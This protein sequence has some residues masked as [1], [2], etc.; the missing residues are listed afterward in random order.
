V[1]AYRQFALLLV[2]FVCLSGHAAWAD[3]SGGNDALQEIVVTAEK[4]ESTVQDTPISMTA[5]SGE[6]LQQEGI[7]G[8][9][10]IIE[11]VPGLSMRTAG[12]GQTELEM[13]GLSSSGGSS[14]TVG[15]YLDDYPLTPAAAALNGKVVID[16][17]LFDLNRVEVL[18]G[19]QGTLY[20]SGSM[21]GTVK[22]VTNV[23]KLNEFEGEVEVIGS[24][25]SGGGFNRGGNLMLNVPLINDVLAMRVVVTDKFT[26]GWISRYVESDFPPPTNP[27]PCGPGWT[28]CVR[29]NVAAVPATDIVPR[30][31]WERLQ[32]GRVEALAQ[33]TSELKITT[34]A[35]YQKIT[36][37]D[38]SEYDAPPG[39]PD[40]HYQPFNADEP[41]YDEFKL[42]GLTASYDFPFAQLT[43]ATAYYTREENQTQDTSEALYSVEGLFGGVPTQFYNIPFNETDSTRQFSEEIRLASTGDG[44]LQWIGG[45]FF[46]KFESIFTEYNASV[47]LAYLSVG[48]AAAN[49][50]GIIYQAHNPYH[51]KQYAVFGQGEYSFAD[52]WK[53][54]AGLR[55]YKFD[56]RADEETA[57]FATDSGNAAATLN[58]FTASNS[59]VNPKVTVS[60]EQNHDLTLYGTIARGFRPG[61]INQQIPASICNLTTETY[62]PDSTWNYEVGEK[63]KT[64]GGR[65]V[66]NADFYYIRWN[67]VQ[68]LAN[69]PC[70]YPL[71]QNAGTA[72]SYGPEIELTALLTQELTLTLTG[73]YTHADLTS[74][75]PSLTEADPAFVPGLPILNIPKYTETAALNYLTPVSSSVK[76][77][78]RINNSLVGP[79]TDVQF[80]YATLPSYDLVGLRFGLVGEHLAGYVFSDNITDKHAELG[81]NTTGFSWTTPSL[82]RIA[83]N[84][85]RTIGVDVT[86]K[87]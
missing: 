82:E 37:G 41:I 34:T 48:G 81:I 45:F 40:A 63:A 84:Q 35:I 36:M 68:Q 85:P 10:G 38:Y 46:S 21:G 64:L 83:T 8:I 58:S 52:H 66:V 15:F 65:L 55:W 78:A 53:L 39:N 6:Q 42:Y 69:Q 86:Y 57:G 9:T 1:K 71:T 12:A 7:S 14:P 30:V 77:M 51:I 13:R 33:P 31:N 2:P 3:T 24:G 23:P 56:S 32:G 20:G 19:P 61:G 47:P 26:D 11:T 25:M 17:D 79:S 67:Q 80:N 73:T 4:R 60:Y 72:Q 54:T 18:R 22:L 43:S 29:G 70:G 62:G 87:F 50:D 28:G 49:P 5:V 59:G 74:V 76:F 44:P 75:N 16:P 27:G